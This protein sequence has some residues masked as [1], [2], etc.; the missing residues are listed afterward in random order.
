MRDG[1][2]P[3]IGAWPCVLVGDAGC[4]G[5]AMRAASPIKGE[6]EGKAMLPEVVCRSIPFVSI[7]CPITIL[8]DPAAAGPDHMP[9]LNPVLF[10]FPVE[11][12]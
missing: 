12:G 6:L 1:T 3:S 4:R 2:R 10:C 8:C 11:T 5:A 7:R 9:P